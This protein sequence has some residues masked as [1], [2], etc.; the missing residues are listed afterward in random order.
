MVELDDGVDCAPDRQSG[1]FRR[2]GI[3]GTAALG[4]AFG[5]VTRGNPARAA[6][7]G[8][9]PSHPRWRVVFVNHVTTNPFFVPTQN[10]LA[11]A[12]ALLGCD[13]QWTGSANSDV[14][15]MVNAMNAA[16]AA[17]AAA[18]AVPLIDPKA[19]DGPTDRALAAGI[20]VF[21][22]NA[23]AP[24]GS[25]NKRL[26]YIGQDLYQAGQLMGQRIVQMV[27]SG[28]IALF[29]ATPGALNLQPRVDGAMDVIKKSGKKYDVQVIA[30]GATVNEEISK[31]ESFYLG[32]QDVRGM[33]AVD[34]GT[35][36]GVAEAMS[37]HG[38]AAKGVIGG[39]F[40]L[41]PRTLS[42]I[43]A[44]AMHFTIDQQPYLQGF[45][46]VMQMFSFLVSGGLVGPASCDTGL[47]FVTKDSVGAYLTTKTRYEGNSDTPEIVP[48]NGPIGT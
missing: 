16:I 32:H 38:L 11:D 9:F 14:A 37:K 25:S 45:Y 21:A 15:E 26:A 31:V 28:T 2:R 6:D 43:Q 36:Q 42:L 4:A 30:T 34:G 39:G 40:D 17:K 35:T 22:Y 47:K 18:I 19:F 24:A 29:I 27:E 13:H 3:L 5:L 46:T 8:P 20:P 44:G 12:C 41:L 1:E 23:D 33:F 48:R 7:A 10:G